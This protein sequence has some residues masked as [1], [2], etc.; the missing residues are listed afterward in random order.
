MIQVTVLTQHYLYLPSENLAN[1]NIN[2]GILLFLNTAPLKFWSK[3]RVSQI[4]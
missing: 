4:E 1:V 3:H 2:I